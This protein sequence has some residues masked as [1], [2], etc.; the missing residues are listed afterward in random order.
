MEKSRNRSAI[1]PPH[2]AHDLGGGGTP[3]AWL[4]T[5][6]PSEAPGHTEERF[7]ISDNYVQTTNCLWNRRN[8]YAKYDFQFLDISFNDYNNYKHT[9]Y[10][11]IHRQSYTASAWLWWSHGH[12]RSC[13]RST[14][15]L[16]HC[17]TQERITKYI[18]S[19]ACPVCVQLY[20]RSLLNFNTWK[21]ILLL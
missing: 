12:C 20:S 19:Y 4:F 21:W 18:N 14:Y 5:M 3:A 11:H 7:D 2:P 13:N 15:M 1:F 17:S 6:L 8:I 9:H 16:S 10:F